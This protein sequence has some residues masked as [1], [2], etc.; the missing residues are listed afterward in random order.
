MCPNAQLFMIITC[1]NCNMLWE[2]LK[3]MCRKTYST[4]QNSLQLSKEIV[5]Y[6]VHFL[7]SVSQRLLL[8]II[9]CKIV[10]Y[11]VLFV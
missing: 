2:M 8:M 5:L 7:Q 1:E 6:T 3:E 10:G 4:E 9:T 11:F